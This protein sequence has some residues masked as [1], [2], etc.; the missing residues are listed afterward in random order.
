MKTSL[1]MTPLKAEFLTHQTVAFIC[2]TASSF[3]SSANGPL[4]ESQTAESWVKWS[5]QTP[6]RTFANIQNQIWKHLTSKGSPSGLWHFFFDLLMIVEFL[7]Q[8]ANYSGIATQQQRLGQ[9]MFINLKLWPWGKY[10][11]ENFLKDLCRMSQQCI[12]FFFF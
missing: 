4:F 8:A 3:L 2:I 7:W 6:K 9:S 12:F 5:W 10:G 11:E 1:Q